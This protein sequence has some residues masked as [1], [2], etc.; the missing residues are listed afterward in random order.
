M[1][2]AEQFRI[3]I[4]SSEYKTIGNFIKQNEELGRRGKLSRQHLLY[5]LKNT[6]PRRKQN[7]KLIKKINEV[8]E[9]H[10]Q[11]IPDGIYQTA[12]KKAETS[13]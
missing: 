6:K 2:K 8:I 9:K 1:T 3:A 10:F 5:V 4:M 7:T 13:S 11:T 12:T